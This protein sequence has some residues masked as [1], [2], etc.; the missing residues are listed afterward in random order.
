MEETA[1]IAPSPVRGR[2]RKPNRKGLIRHAALAMRQ[3]LLRLRWLHLR[4]LGMDIHPDT[5][6][7]L[8][9][10]LDRT[11]PRG[12]HIGEGTLV[13]FGAAILSH[14]LVRVMHTDTYIGRNCFIGARSIILPGIHVGDG[15]IVAIGSVVTKDVTPN[16][17][18]AGNPA[19]VIRTGIRTRKW[20][21][22]EEDYQQALAIRSGSGEKDGES[23]L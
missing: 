20:G 14:D 16:T 22:L 12:I 10:H 2:R 11:N 1:Q 15:S 21:V 4:S 13:A 6:I 23:A 9:A 3:L 5:E 19:R 17:I 7:S 8:K 18:V